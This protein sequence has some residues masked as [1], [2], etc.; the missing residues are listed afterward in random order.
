MDIRLALMAGVDIPIPELQLTVHQPTL[1]EIAYIGEN[2]FFTGVQCLCLYKSMFIQDKDGLDDITNFQIF[3]TVMM[4]KATIDK[5]LATMQVLEL[6]FPQYK[7]L[8]T[9]MSLIFVKGEEN[10]TVD[11]SNFDFLQETLRVVFCAKDGPMDQQAFNPANEKAR[12]IAEK[13][14]RGRQRVAA[15]KGGNNSSV[16]SRYLSIL[17]IGISSM[18]LLD[19]VNLT[20]FQLYDLIER[21]ILHMRWD[22]DVRTRLAGGKP[23]S[24][25]DDWMKDIH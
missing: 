11:D 8:F 4:D 19:L 13:L 2:D 14:M 24:Q 7:I 15:Q 22:I 21:Y 25:P 18:S 9:P 16:F 1:R 12:E 10:I 17:T 3:M 5:K 6:I 23:D 20:M